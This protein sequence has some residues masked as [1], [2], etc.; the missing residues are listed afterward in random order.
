MLNYVDTSV[1]KI[2]AINSCF[3]AFGYNLGLTILLS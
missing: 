3:I 1:Y 2:Y